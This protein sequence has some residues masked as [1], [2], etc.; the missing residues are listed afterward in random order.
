MAKKRPQYGPEDKRKALEMLATETLKTV[1]KRLGISVATL[2]TWKA[3]QPYRVE[4]SQPVAVADSDA[5]EL[6]KIENEF[7]KRKLAILERKK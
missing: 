7:L 3:T 2:S 4:L 6:L 5:M 1:S